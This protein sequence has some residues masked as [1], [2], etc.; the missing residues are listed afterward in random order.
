MFKFM[1]K[2]FNRS[3]V[4]FLVGIIVGIIIMAGGVYAATL[5]NS[6]DVF[7]DNANST[8]SSTNVQGAIDELYTKSKNLLPRY[9]FGTPTDSS[10][11]DFKEVI[12]SSGSNVFV[13]KMGSQLSVC[14]YY[15]NDLFCMKNGAANWETNKAMLNTAT[16][17]GVTCSA[18]SSRADCSDDSFNCSVVSFGYV[19][20]DVGDVDL[21][22]CDV[23]ADGSVDCS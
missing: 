2:L 8:L 16:F 19:Y 1:K 12:A 22:R 6:K 3:K 18:S 14:L 11:T 7:Y 10:P 17:P 20:C 15:N 4:N 9:A 13:R 23:R 5:V 21:R